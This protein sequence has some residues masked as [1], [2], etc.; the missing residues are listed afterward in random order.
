MKYN[1]RRY[2]VNAEIKVK[3]NG[4]ASDILR[5]IKK[6]PLDSGLDDLLKELTSIY[7][8]DES[9]IKNDVVNFVNDT[10]K[11]GKL[12]CFD[13]LKTNEEAINNIHRLQK[14]IPGL[15]VSDFG[16]CVHWGGELSPGC[17]SCQKGQWAVM[18]VCPNC[19]L[20]CHS[21]PYTSDRLS[22]CFYYDRFHC[23]RCEVIVFAG[24]TFSSF[25][26]LKLQFSLVKNEYNAFA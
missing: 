22:D 23:D 21:C 25:R 16:Y 20:Y 7:N 17:K 24:V 5:L 3:A 8:A 4:V 2:V 14:G 10:L 19:N 13:S 11:S 15:L 1:G 9:T 6:L 12:V 18:N 26:E